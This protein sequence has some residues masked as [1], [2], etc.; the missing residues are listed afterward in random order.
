MTEAEFYSTAAE[1]GHML[2]FVGSQNRYECAHCSWNIA[3]NNA[4]LLGI[5]YCTRSKLRT[6][7]KP[8]SRNISIIK[9]THLET[10]VV[11]RRA[12]VTFEL[13]LEEMKLDKDPNLYHYELESIPYF[14]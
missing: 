13:M 5:P 2:T 1:K 14:E 12:Y 8:P 9:R 3:E 4:S 10:K 6:H 7:P 11:D